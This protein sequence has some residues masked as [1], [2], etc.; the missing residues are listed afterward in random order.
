MSSYHKATQINMIVPNV[1]A[2]QAVLT[3][4]PAS[5]TLRTPYA[6]VEVQVGEVMVTDTKQL[7][8]PNDRLHI[9]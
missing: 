9:P 1:A 3:D 6:T 8:N 7:H 4:T 5:L 2:V